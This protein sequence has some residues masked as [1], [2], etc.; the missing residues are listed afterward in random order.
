MEY[1]AG[2]DGRVAGRPTGVG[3]PMETKEVIG[4]FAVVDVPSREE[5]LTAHN[6]QQQ[7]QPWSLAS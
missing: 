3:H 2:P 7:H 6:A 1:A 5:A 4:G